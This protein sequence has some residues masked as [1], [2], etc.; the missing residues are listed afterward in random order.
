MR[1]SNVYEESSLGL[2]AEDPDEDAWPLPAPSGSGGP[3]GGIKRRLTL[4]GNVANAQNREDRTQF[5]RQQ[6]RAQLSHDLWWVVLALFVIMIIEG[7]QF[8]RNPEAFSVFNFLFEV[9]SAYGCVGISVGVPNDAYSFCGAWHKL[10]KLVLIAVMLRGRHRGLPVAIDQAIK[11]PGRKDIEAEFG[12]MESDDAP[13][14]PINRPNH[15]STAQQPGR[16]GAFMM[17]KGKQ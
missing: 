16:A 2:F 5:V 9:I 3:F 7:S 1:N 4:V 8:E 6:V 10:S 11:L 17:A 14:S 13:S 15:F 12:A